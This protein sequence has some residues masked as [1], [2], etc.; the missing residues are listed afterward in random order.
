VLVLLVYLCKKVS[1]GE[2]KKPALASQEYEL[3]EE[4]SNP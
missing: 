3:Q 1:G 2:T 4:K